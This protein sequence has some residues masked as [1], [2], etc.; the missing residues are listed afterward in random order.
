MHRLRISDHLKRNMIKQPITPRRVL[1]GLTLS[2][3]LQPLLAQTDL[4]ET[5]VVASRSAQ[6]VDSVTADLTILDNDTLL[7]EGIYDLDRAIRR[8]SGVIVNSSGQAGTT[9]SIRIRGLRS[10]DTQLRIDGVRMTNRLGSY[11]SLVAQSLLFPEEEISIL[12]GAQGALYGA[13]STGGVVNIGDSDSKQSRNSIFV[14]AGSFN[15]LQAGFSYAGSIGKLDYRLAEKY[16]TTDNDT[17][18]DYSEKGGYDADFR[19]HST[20]LKLGYTLDESTRF[21][22]SLRSLSSDTETPHYGGSIA[23]NSFL[24]SSLF[25]ERQINDSWQTT[26]RLSYLNEDTDFGGAYGPSTLDYEQFGIAWENTLSLSDISSLSFGAEYEHTDYKG[27]QAANGRSDYY[28]AIYA[29]HRLRIDDLTLDAGLRYEDYQSFGNHLSWRTGA[30]Y[31][32]KQSGTSLFGNVGTGFTTPTILQLFSP[33]AYGVAGN[34][35][36]GP[37]TSLAWDLGVE[38]TIA[39]DHTLKLSYFRTDIENIIAP[40]YSTQLYENKA[41]SSSASG[42]EASLAGE[43]SS[44]LSYTLSYTWLDQSFNGQ[45]KNTANAQLKYAVTDAITLGVGAEYLG[46]RS[47]GGSPLDAAFIARIFGNYHVNENLQ[48]SARIENVTDAHYLHSSFYGTEYPA[49]RLGTFLG[50]KYEW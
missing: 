5:T 14:E 50:A 37:E 49:A 24:L 35:K 21:G 48:L 10:G 39:K 29:N 12:K 30:R 8:V 15:T 3:A 17:Y 43:L 6:S 44:S 41:N 36:L 19:N 20:L 42:I 33:L 11:Q 16:Y 46:K 40:N 28:K 23:D 4:G 25:A 1:A 9:H 18:G 22:F 32:L 27:Y 38:Q 31:D 45:P 7:D 13:G 47:Y 2:A 26:L 34:P